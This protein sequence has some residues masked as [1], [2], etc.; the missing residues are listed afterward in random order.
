MRTNPNK[1]LTPRSQTHLKSNN[2]N[3]NYGIDDIK[4]NFLDLCEI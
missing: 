2:R 4:L 3:K 1:K